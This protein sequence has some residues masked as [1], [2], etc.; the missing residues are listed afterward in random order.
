MRQGI[1]LIILI[2]IFSGCS[3]RESIEWIPFDWKG[4]TISG[5]YIEKAYIYIPVKIDNLPCDFTMQLDLGTTETQF[6]GKTIEP[7]L[8]EFPSLASKL[9]SFQR[10]K[11][12]IFRDVNLQ[13]GAVDFKFNVW[14]RYN[15][16][17]EILKDSLLSKT[18]K[19]IGTIG[20]DMFQNKVLILDYKLKRFA[21]SN[22]LPV[23]YEGLPSVGFEIV[24]DII[25]L[26]FNI[27]GKKCKLMFDTGSSPFELVTS[28]AKAL[29]I[30]DSVIIDSL[31][32]PLWWGNEITFYGMRVN[33][34]IEFG[35]EILK[36]TTVYYDK[37][38]LWEGIFD[39]L[40]VWGIT[41]N[42]YF[43]DDVVIVDYVNR[44][45]RVKQESGHSRFVFNDLKR[46]SSI[47]NL[48]QITD[49][50]EYI[51]LETNDKSIIPDIWDFQFDEEYMFILS[52]QAG[53]FQFTREGKFVRKLSQQGSGPQGHSMPLA[54]AID[55]ARKKVYLYDI[56]GKLLIFSYEGEFISYH[57]IGQHTFVKMLVIDDNEVLIVPYNSTGNP[58]AAFY[59]YY[60][61]E[62]RA[63]SMGEIVSFNINP[64][65][66]L[67]PIAKA[68]FK[69]NNEIVIHPNYSNVV[70]TYSPDNKQ[71][72]KRHEFL[73]NTPFYPEQLKRGYGALKESQALIDISE[74]RNYIYAA[75]IDKGMIRK[76]HIIDKKGGVFHLADF[77]YGA[78]FKSSFMPK[79]QSGN[80][81][82]EII[83]MVH[84][85]YPAGDL[86][87]ERERAAATTFFSSRTGK[88]LT[89]ESNPVVV[90]VELK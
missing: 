5:K 20:A 64:N 59:H 78:G 70:Y 56:S 69:V 24:D 13:M 10:Y 4:D 58:S 19:H 89:I 77:S 27:D 48:A 30:S 62:G 60:L 17:E 75:I 45:F 34:P 8:E 81:I 88:E 41:G 35:E 42:A 3:Q 32:G 76:L 21:M 66:A 26:P 73:F 55:S 11:D 61:E 1:F 53:L 25:K 23:E 87:T 71:F 82:A 86:P 40:S 7:Y 65:R 47:L 63:D 16:G 68:V 14:H 28:K 51:A 36:S 9:D 85:N 22:S 50:V 38:G 79:Y 80:M 57:N 2:S 90:I 44:L 67:P 74:G 52:A 6:Y 39:S 54:I 72:Y 49:K 18:P 43:S 31:S 29:E 37:D 15:F 83:G 33:K 46:A 84:L 12:A